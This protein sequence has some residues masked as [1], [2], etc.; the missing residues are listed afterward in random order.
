MRTGESFS[1]TISAVSQ[2]TKQSAPTKLTAI[3]GT[4]KV[5]IKNINKLKE[6]IAQLINQVQTMQLLK[7]IKVA[8]AKVFKDKYS[9]LRRY[10]TLINMY[11]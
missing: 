4:L 10:L 5:N 9:T 2:S 8:D 6:Q 7:G 1:I 11:I 3:P